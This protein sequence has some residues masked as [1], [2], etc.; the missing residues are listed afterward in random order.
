MKPA[1]CLNISGKKIGHN[2]PTYFVADIAA[3]R[4]GDLRRAIDL[5]GL[6]AEA[7]ANA[8]KFQHF[9]AETIV[10]DAGFKNLGRQLSHQSK[11]KKTVF[12]VY[13]DA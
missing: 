6:A 3:N 2:E 4:D 9:K 5:V 10:S 8:A 13:Q 11:W 1:N 12:E 7:G